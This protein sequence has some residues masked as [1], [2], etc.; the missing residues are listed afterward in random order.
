MENEYRAND[1]SLFIPTKK[2]KIFP[3]AQGINIKPNGNGTSQ[4][5]FN[6]PDYISFF[7]PETLRL[8]FNLQMQGRQLPKPDAAAACSSLFRHMRV[9]T[10]NGLNLLE[11]VEEMS[12]AVAGFYSYTADDGINSDRSINE[13]LSLTNNSANQ[14]FWNS[15]PLPSS[16][17]TT[18]LTSKKVAISLPLHASGILGPSASVVPNAALGGTKL[19][20]HTNNIKKSIRLAG[21]SGE[22]G[23]KNALVKT[24][25]LAAA[26]DNPSLTHV[27]DITTKTPDSGD[28]GFSIGDALYYKVGTTD[29]L[30]GILVSV[31]NAAG[32]MTLKV[33]ANVPINTTGPLLAVDTK[34]Y[35]LKQNVYEGW[36]PGVNMQGGGADATINTAV[37]A[38]K[39]KVDYTITDLEMIVEQV[40][41]PQSYIDD[42]VRKI[43][44]STGLIMN[45]RNLSLHKVNLVGQTG[46][47]NASINN[48]AKRVYSLNAMPLASTDTYDAGNLV[49]KPDGITS[50]QWEINNRLEP[51]QRVPLSRLSMTPAYVEQLALQE[52]YKSLTNAGHFVKSLQNAEKN[53]VIGRAV[54]LFG[55][56]SDITKSDLS[57][58][59]EYG[60]TASY[61]KTLNVYATTARTLIVQKNNIEVVY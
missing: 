47:L 49:A 53:F 43:N 60:S 11:E 17:I 2:L 50:Y 3:L 58:R 19:T 8:R 24:Q 33:R 48:T 36:T 30:I 59:L 29:T 40:Q 27:V 38:A 13:G 35:T 25:V 56:V 46:L 23:K 4:F 21:D 6:I 41:P 57:L 18:P 61:A 51:D 37:A 54:S 31:G 10:Q 20:L 22:N 52:T 44:S 34:L 45:Y 26:W 14:L 16:N 39:V 7:N 9:Q 28:C 5:V 42:M 12:S 1:N 55:S 15:Q 32:D